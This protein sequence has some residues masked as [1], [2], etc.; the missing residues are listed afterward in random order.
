MALKIGQSIKG[1]EVELETSTWSPD[2]FASMCD[3]L[4]WAVSGRNCTS[5]PSFTNRVNAADGGID[6]EWDLE[7]PDDG[8][9]IPTPLIGTGWNVFQ[10]KSRSIT[11]SNR[12]RIIANLRSGLKGAITDIESRFHRT[13]DRYTLFI[14]IDLKHDQK[15]V[16]KEAI[17]EGYSGYSG[18]H[19]EVVGAGEL[20]TFLN[21]NPHL[22]YAFFATILFK[23]WEEAYKAHRSH[24]FLGA[25]VD[26]IGR[27]DDIRR[28]SLLIRDE[29]I[30]VIIVTG[31]HD[32]GKSR[33][34]LE[35][36]KDRPHDVV[37]AL[38]PRSMDL[39]DY[40]R[41]VSSHGEVICIVEDPEPDIIQSLAIEVLTIPNLKLIVTLPTCS[42][43][44]IPSYGL[45]ERIQNLHLEPLDDKC[46]HELLKAI[47]LPRDLEIE[48][49]IIRQAGGIPGILL[50]AGSLGPNLRCGQGDLVTSVGKEFEKRIDSGLGAEA[51]K[52]AGLFSILTHVGI[53]G[54]F[55][56]EIRC[57][58]DSFG[59]GWQ[60]AD[61]MKALDILEHAGLAR[62]GGSFAWISIP[63]LANHLA[64]RLIRVRRNEVFALY[65]RLELPG[66]MR[67]LRRLCEI[68]GAE[69]EGFWDEMFSPDGPLGKTPFTS[70]QVKML[71]TI[72]GAAPERTIKLLEKSML[73]TTREERLSIDGEIRRGLMWALEQL[74]FRA[75]TS[76]R[77][78]RLIWLLAEVEND[79]IYSNN[80]TGVLKEAFLMMHPQMPL[81]LWE[82]IEALR[83]FTSPHESR[84]GK[85]AAIKA[86]GE[87]IGSWSIIIRHSAGPDFL[88]SRPCFSY[89]DACHYAHELIDIMIS[90]ASMEEGEVAC[91]AI[92]VLPGLIIHYATEGNAPEAL[93]R[94]KI[95]VDWAI[96]GKPGLDI[97]IISESIINIY[98]SLSDR[99]KNP[100]CPAHKKDELCKVLDE[101]KCLEERLE[102]GDF[103]LRLKLWS[104]K[105]FRR[106]TKTIKVKGREIHIFEKRLEEL[107][108]EAVND[109]GLLTEDI[110]S[111]L[112]YHATQKSG[113]FF[114]HLGLKDK[115]RGF[116]DLMK[117]FAKDPQGNSAFS[118]YFRGWAKDEPDA[119]GMFLDRF[120]ESGE[121][122]AEALIEATLRMRPDNSRVKR[123][124][125]LIEKRR[126]D[127]LSAGKFMSH[128]WIE[129]IE[130]DQGMELLRIIAGAGFENSA[131][132][133][134]MINANYR[135]HLASNETLREF[136]WRCL[137]NN[138]I[139][140][141][142]ADAYN[143]DYLAGKLA[144]YDL[145]RGFRLLDKLLH[146]KEE[147]NLWHPLDPFGTHEFR[148]V[149]YGMD[150]ECLLE[151][152]FKVSK[153]DKLRRFDITQYLKGFLDFEKERDLL[154]NFAKKDEEIACIISQCITTS[155]PGFW[156]IAFELVKSY[157]AN[158]EIKENLEAGIEQQGEV[159][160]G[161][162]S[163]FYE[164]RK[165][166]IDQLLADPDTP[167]EVHYWLHSFS[168]RLKK[169]TSRELIWEYDRDIND[170]REAIE[171]RESPERI[172]A[173]GRVL[174]YG[175]PE[176]WKRLLRVE[177]IE[178]ALPQIDLPEK[179]R[180]V[181][182]RALKVW[183]NEI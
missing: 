58:C 68:S 41:L 166:E 42:H 134:Y 95:L 84:E 3:A 20:A 171:N 151:L 55:E 165:S 5:L 12:D 142:P 96:S 153:A 30:R 1:D 155:K 85:I 152:L 10:Y 125:N 71:E 146:R 91:A 37:M 43:I 127:P 53:A 132:A 148:D 73:N 63:I 105:G 60:P 119:A 123:I 182:E 170:L 102:S 147:A 106:D 162:F 26:L 27:E 116:L 47:G 176:D 143:F 87:A 126:V 177:D 33:L 8:N 66:R 145:E 18:I 108:E 65:A 6:A 157:P 49:W 137:E 104:G 77:A 32:I 35:A 23:T 88:D 161:P 112:I 82:R 21:D 51:L 45:D 160:C 31:P 13:P 70:D 129:Y 131:M 140:R 93:E 124:I 22:K 75:G 158:H 69:V 38:D 4:I 52:G 76:R 61:A 81:P 19:A 25:D 118:S 99:V 15:K 103:F 121:L 163:K 168:D 46:S 86:A 97:S 150:K 57:I 172:W 83:E 28:L 136:A 79:E 183:N 64:G 14:N 107:A 115:E 54:G 101:L 128:G 39:S 122:N 111:W 34:V 174:K 40:H 113:V 167:K 179:K 59:N 110:I 130:P 56:P 17:L 149:L 36:T 72:S 180:K 141:P 169:E 156:P 2:R 138:P 139:I 164:E 62:R 173:I 92:E 114:Y 16:I 154:L 78:L 144:G 48:E 94:L 178:E 175:T 98:D 74:L 11:S 9:P 133:I 44:H 117:G 29:R 159:I 90:I 80:A 109:S 100:Q 135:K 7:I 89:P 50:A 67:F 120:A 181:I 24:K